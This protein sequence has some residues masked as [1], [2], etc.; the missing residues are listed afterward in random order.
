MVDRIECGAEIEQYEDRHF[1]GFD[2]AHELIV[3]G[4]NCSLVR[5]VGSISRLVRRLQAFSLDVFRETCSDDALDG[6]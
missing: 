5:V 6:L 2:V 1:A 4:C 3:D